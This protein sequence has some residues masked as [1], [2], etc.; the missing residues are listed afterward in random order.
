MWVLVV[1][2]LNSHM[3]FSVPGFS[4]ERTCSYQ[5]EEI[6]AFLRDVKGGSDWAYRCVKPN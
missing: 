3:A 6:I 2:A 5:G 4:T 1:L